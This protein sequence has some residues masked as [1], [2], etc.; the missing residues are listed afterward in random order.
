MRE[1]FSKTRVP[2]SDTKCTVNAHPL[3]VLL[4]TTAQ[5]TV[6]TLGAM[7]KKKKLWHESLVYQ[8]CCRDHW[9]DSEMFRMHVYELVPTMCTYI[10]L[11]FVYI[12]DECHMIQ[13]LVYWVH[14]PSTALL[15]WSVVRALHYV[16]NEPRK[17]QSGPSKECTVHIEGR[18]SCR[19]L[20]PSDL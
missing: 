12:H 13:Y 9:W 4:S 16:R 8:W 10:F 18:R 17:E 15:Y 11:V 7:S 3:F 2:I 5:C 1:L 14:K 19:E 20:L 6:S